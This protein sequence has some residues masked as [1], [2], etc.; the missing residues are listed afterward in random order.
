L[1][2]EDIADAI[3]YCV[4]APDR[5]SIADICIYPKAQAEPRTVF[6]K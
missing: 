5:V 6:R 3:S 2:A 1:I 4:N